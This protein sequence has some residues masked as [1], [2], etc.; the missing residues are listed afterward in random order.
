MLSGVLLDIGC[1]QERSAPESALEGA[2]SVVLQR[3]NPLESTPVVSARLAEVL[4]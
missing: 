4:P 3:Q 2:L 1:S